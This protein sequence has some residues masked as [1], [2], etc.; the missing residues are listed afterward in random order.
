MSEKES[1]V[2]AVK[3][4]KHVEFDGNGLKMLGDGLYR[5]DSKEI[6]DIDK[7]VFHQVAAKAYGL[8]K[9][10]IVFLVDGETVKLIL[11]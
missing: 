5:Y 3:E 7:E 11:V 1:K 6:A 10:D 2:K 4:K 9:G 8:R